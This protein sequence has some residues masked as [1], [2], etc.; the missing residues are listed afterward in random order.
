MTAILA[1]VSPKTNFSTLLYAFGRDSRH[2]AHLISEWTAKPK[3]GRVD[4]QIKSVKWA[5]ECVRN[6]DELEEHIAR[7]LPGG[8]YHGSITSGELKEY[9]LDFRTTK[10]RKVRDMVISS[11]S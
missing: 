8:K 7:F 10:P 9:V 1:G 11:G 6:R 3:G 2:N 4:F 5:I